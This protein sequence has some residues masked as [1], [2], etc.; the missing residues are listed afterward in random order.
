MTSLSAGS[1]SCL[2]RLSVHSLRERGRSN[3]GS[4]AGNGGD[5]DGERDDLGTH[6]KQIITPWTRGR[7]FRNR[8]SLSDL[9]FRARAASVLVNESG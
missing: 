8:K 9:V 1:A 2:V 6:I 5:G 4:D 3:A 7:R